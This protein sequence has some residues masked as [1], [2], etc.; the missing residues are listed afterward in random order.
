MPETDFDNS[1]IHF[2]KILLPIYLLAGLFSISFSGIY[3]LVMPLSLLFWPGE[4]YHALEMGILITSM[5]WVMS[6]SGIFFGRLIDKYSR[7]R[8][9]FIVSMVRGFC[10]IMLSFATMAKGI[11]SW[12][13]F[14]FFIFIFS[15]FAGGNY[16]TVIS[17]SHDIVPI[18]QRSRFF[19]IYGIV[20]YI[21]QLIGFLISG[22]LVQEGYWRF[23]FSGIGIALIISGRI[24]VF[25][26]K[27]PKRGAQREELSEILK[28][29]SIEYNFQINKEMM[30]KT[31]LSKTN[32]IVLIEGIFTNVFLGSLTIL[33]LPYIQGEPHN[34]A[35]FTTAVFLASFGL[36]AGILG[37][38]ILARLSDKLCYGKE[39]RRLYFIIFALAIGAF[40]FVFM[41]YLPLPHLTIKEGKD[42]IYFFSFPTIWIM[43]AIYLS[44]N[45]I[46][47]LYD[48][49]QPPLLQE[50]NLPEAQ[51]QIVSWNRL[52]ENI[53]F[54]SG[55]LIT[56]ILIS[57]SGQNY[58]IVALFIGLFTMP[59]IFLWIF[60]FKWYHRDKTVIKN[61]LKQRAE[62]IKANK[63][64]NYKSK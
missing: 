45:S 3:I 38:I 19:G 14:Y 50:I 42:I 25:K 7:K 17:L 34:F 13:Y 15:F 1:K 2:N 32:L 39:I 41:F 11:D 37:K 44:A 56:G 49:N 8:I 10:M 58:Q 51:G 48:V 52:L 61:I 4:P 31:M 62:I 35:P 9:F 59:G 27:E 57:I 47:S 55:P 54:G 22:Y 63:K 26:I 24:M 40:S 33:F 6:G 21:F 16:P 53:G 20:R 43:G 12:L 23:F 60:A 29:D 28:E 46:S 30:L 5:F 64:K 18:S 36:I